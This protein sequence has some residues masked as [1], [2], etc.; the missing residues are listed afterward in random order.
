[1]SRFAHISD[2]HFGRDRP[3]LLAP[4]VETLNAA[5]LDVVLVSGDLTQRARHR[6][7]AA[8]R[9]FLDR[10]EVPWIAVPGNH[11]TPLD[12]LWVRLVRPWSRFRKHISQDLEP[13]FD[14]HRF[15]VAG[16]NTAD[17]KAW[18]RGRLRNNSLSRIA[19]RMRAAQEAG[20]VG[21]VMMHHP[22]E[23]LEEDSKQPMRGSTH[24]LRRLADMGADLVLCGH[25]H[26]WRA[27]PAR[28]SGGILILQVGTGLS[29]RLRGHPN[30]FNIVTVGDDGIAIDR[31]GAAADETGFECLSQHR[32]TK[33]NGYWQD[34]SEPR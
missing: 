12:N 6:Q 27:L 15:S 8:A 24:G 3:E 25:L 16:L 18:Q 10:L 31:Y 23:H 29:N 33:E 4:L 20:K 17:P 34:L 7:F 22:P 9:A 26:V 1:M 2:L 32:F 11:D 13:G 21:I 19:T 5:E 28:Q 14:A 30:D